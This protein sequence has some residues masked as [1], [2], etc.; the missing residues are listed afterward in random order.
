MAQLS[1]A[2]QRNAAASEQ[3]AATA[4]DLTGHATD[5]QEMMAF[6]PLRAAA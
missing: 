2:T 6:F 5:L 1:E 4:E 3:L